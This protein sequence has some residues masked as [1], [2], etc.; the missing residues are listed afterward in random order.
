M[1]ISTL[2]LNRMGVNGILDQQ[3]ALAQVQNKLASGKKI[4]SPADD[5]S[6]SASIIRLAQAKTL[7]EQYQRNSNQAA[8]RLTLEESAL[9]NVENAL[10][11]I[12]ELAV[13]ANNST[14][15]DADRRAIG[16]EVRQRLDEII[17][18]AN[19]RDSNGEYLFAGNQVSQRPFSR[20]ADGSFSYN[21]DQGQRLIQIS[22]ERRVADSDSGYKVFMDIASGNGKFQAVDNPVNTGSGI[23][24]LGSVTDISA[25]VSDTYTITMV[26]N[27]S[28][29]LGYN[30]I[31]AATGQVIPP[32]PQ[33]PVTDAP[34]FSS[35]TG[36]EFKGI[37][38]KIT[39]TPA[40]GDT[41]V[42]KP[43]GRHDIFTIVNDLATALE[44][45]TAGN[46]NNTRVLNTITSSLQNIDN[47]LEHMVEFR[48]NVGAR[49]NTIDDQRSVND[50][51]QIELQATA[52][53]IQD[54]D[55][56]SAISEL[57]ARSYA[58]QAAQSSF[59][60]IQGL[61]LFNFL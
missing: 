41:Y 61:S 6:G 26:T 9:S 22:P 24:D 48:A 27:G 36:I 43:P 58:L 57:Q 4:L 13:Q 21:A 23:I 11:R 34:D 60:R 16:M 53:K 30:V 18:T 25:Y 28:G 45:G 20:Q 5:P 39:G 1:R 29:N 12:R 7:T 54:L 2:L 3:G 17:S 44:T 40:A 35:G 50:A 52:S 42:I 10:Q 56:V 47:A 32:L 31:G 51:F 55:M 46:A 33:D 59:S 8:N 49:L 38:T 19:S 14:L 15:D 37:E